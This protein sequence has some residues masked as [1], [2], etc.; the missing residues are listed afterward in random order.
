MPLEL[1]L[2]LNAPGR[3]FV[4]GR[5]LD[6]ELGGSLRL[7]GTT[8]AT[9]PAGSF[10]LIRGRLDLLGN[11]FVLTDGSASM[12]GSFLPFIR[13]TATTE[14]G[15]V[16]TS[17]TLAGQADSPEITFSSVPELPQDEVLARLIFRRALT[18]LSPFQ[19][20]Q[21]ALS[22]ATLTGRADDSILGRTRA[23]MGL[24]D[25]D[26]TVDA[27]GNTQLRAGRALG[28]RVYTDVSVDSAGRGEVSINLNLSPS[29]TLRGRA[30]TQGGSGIGLFFERD[31]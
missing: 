10:Q 9:V 14:S 2:V 12:I 20:A 7:G 6:A 8:R 30:D 27:Q 4:R 19:A 5:G 22:V 24:D 23:A 11:R 26:F 28:E 31:Y 18:S 13:L 17:V 25:L 16:L 1:D 15:G 3:V 29:V 21:L